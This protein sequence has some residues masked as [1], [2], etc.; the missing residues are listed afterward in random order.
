MPSN[1]LLW[2]RIRALTRSNRIFQTDRVFQDQSSL[3]RI[4]A[5]SEFLDWNQQASILDQTNV[6]L[7]RLQR[8][9]DYDMMD[10][11]G[12]INLALDLY[13][14]ESCLTGD[15]QVP[16]LDGTYPTIAELADKG[17]DNE[18]WVY[19]YDVESDCYVPAKA[20]G[21]RVSGRNVEVFK[22]TL[23]DG[24]SLKCTGH[25]L[26]MLNT[27][28]YRRADQLKQGDSLKP[29]YKK[30]RYRGKSGRALFDE[31]PYPTATGYEYFY[32]GRSYTSTHRWVYHHCNDDCP[33][34]VHHDNY[35][36]LDNSPNNLIGLTNKE[37]DVIHKR[38]GSSNPSYNAITIEDIK[39]ALRDWRGPLTREDVCALCDIGKR[40]LARVLAENNYTWHK[41]RDEYGR[42]S[43][44]N[45]GLSGCNKVCDDC[46][47]KYSHDWYLR[48]RNTQSFRDR[49]LLASRRNYKSV[50]VRTCKEC[51]K[52]KSAK[53]FSKNGC[54]YSPYYDQCRQ[55][56]CQQRYLKKSFKNHKVVSVEPD[57]VVDKVY[58]IEVP[59]YHCFAAGSDGSFVIVHNSI[60]DSERKHT[61]V[62]RA[63]SRRLKKELEELLFGTLM[64]DSQCRPCIRYLCKFG[65]C[66]YEIVPTRNRDGVASLRHMNVYNFTRIE[67]KYGDLVG[68]F[69]QDEV[70]PEPVFLH[71]WQVMHLRLNSLES[72][73]SPYGRAV[74]DGG[75]KAFKS[76]RMMEDSAVIHRLTRA[77]DKRKFIIPV[78]NI[79]TKEIP[80]YMEMVAR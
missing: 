16:L 34:V 44:C 41:F 1:W 56:V 13:A 64:W 42:C 17:L 27:G 45:V 37:H 73:Y 21:A 33:E 54:A 55:V 71:P 14:D 5:G 72:S 20:R 69:Y 39:L 29:L 4:V 53:D 8:Y 78:G 43:R 50:L 32:N 26:F 57:G 18:F 3:D 9:K 79:P 46:K 19:S 68:F 38:T 59:G 75:R 48:N 23:D 31:K 61:V 49:R 70:L 65:D 67:T 12:E 52:P 62:I 6:H 24:K 10:Q 40:V 15:V 76:L 63:R 30:V 51:Q 66:P 80:E 36:S 74:I 25:H 7:N 35:R 22:V 58:D 2:D 77:A 11:T 60:V 28:E 47:A